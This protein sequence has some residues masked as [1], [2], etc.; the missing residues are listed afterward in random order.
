MAQHRF[1]IPVIG[2]YMVSFSDEEMKVKR[3][4]VKAAFDKSAVVVK[5]G[6]INKLRSVA[7]RLS[8][9][10]DRVQPTSNE[11]VGVTT[12]FVWNGKRIE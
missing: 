11:Q 7:D 3:T 9:L 4:E 5:Q 6:C 10:A 12:S 1:S 8:R 2:G